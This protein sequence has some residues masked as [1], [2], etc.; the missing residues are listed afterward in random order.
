MLN[1]YTGYIH[2]KVILK[3]IY[4]IFLVIFVNIFSSRVHACKEIIYR[5]NYLKLY[6][7]VFN[8]SRH[9]LSVANFRNNRH[10]QN[11]NNHSQTVYLYL[12]NKRNILAI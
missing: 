6:I 11:K 12:L 10:Q 3:Y 5:T 7:F 8:S 9:Y 4:T 2:F 1:V